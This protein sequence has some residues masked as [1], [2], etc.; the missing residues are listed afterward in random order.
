MSTRL[1]FQRRAVVCQVLHRQYGELVN[2]GKGCYFR[3]ARHRSVRIGKFAEDPAGPQSRQA[4]EVHGRLGVPPALQD[5][6]GAGFQGEDMARAMRSSGFASTAAAV[7]TV[8]TRSAADTPVV[9]PIAASI[10]TV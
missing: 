5:P 6:P 4:H 3:E 1:A 8:M 7:L 10:D 2:F 9:T